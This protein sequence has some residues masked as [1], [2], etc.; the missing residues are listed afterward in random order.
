[1]IVVTNAGPLIY[2]G[3]I[4]R[5]D[6]LTLLFS[7][8]LTTPEVFDEVVIRGKQLKFHDAWEVENMFK[9]GKFKIKSPSKQSL[10]YVIRICNNMGVILAQ[11]ELSAIALALDTNA[12]FL[13]NDSIAMKVAK[14]LNIESHGVLYVLL[15]SVK[16]RIITCELA[17]E[18]MQKIINAGL[19]IKKGIINKFLLELSKLQRC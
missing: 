6:L 7:E 18:L 3:K 5:L 12:M 4:K 2:L 8:V 13:T 9:K 14:F 10:T 16:R 11:G 17:K 15:E 1:M 19:W